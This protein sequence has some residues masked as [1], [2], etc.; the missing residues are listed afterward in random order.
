M[1]KPISCLR[2]CVIVLGV[3]G[4]LHGRLAWAQL[5]PPAGSV[6]VAASSASTPPTVTLAAALDA[7][8]GRAA[9]A[10]ESEALRRRA[11]A[12]RAVASSLWAAPPSLEFVL[13]DDRFHG[14]QGQREAEIGVTVPLW[15]PG[16]RSARG[17]TVSAAGAQAEAA[18]RVARL[19]LAGELRLAA[20]SL[21]VL[22]A[23]AAQVEAQVQTLHQLA[24][25]VER[26]VRAGDLARADALAAQAELLSARALQAEARQAARAGFGHWTLLTGLSA[27]PEL[28]AEPAALNPPMHVPLD[29]PE[30]QLARLATEHAR[31]RLDLAQQS[32]REPP[33]LLLGLRQDTAGRGQSSQGGVVV[34][35]RLPF[36]TDD[37]NLP[38]QAAAL[39]E[40]DI[41]ESTEPRL[42]DRLDSELAGARGAEQSAQA[43]Y[44]AEA[45]RARLLR[46]RA[47]LIDR[48]FRAGETA[49]PDLLRAIA[50][51]AQ[52]DSAAT[53][54]QAALG[55]AHARRQQALGLLP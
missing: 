47:T 21:V 49:L 48:S 36:G 43:Q 9:A 13:R 3:A 29:H 34:G 14:N 4:S 32:G 19:R 26:R 12:D 45:A 10:R 31:R 42:R 15:L 35:M 8:W 39:S 46:E 50:L 28:E 30:L 22:L 53:R 40:L 38:L 23:D 55:L 33:V 18:E 51:A 24:E 37:R 41:A 54:Q 44:D 1:N 52:A 5:V 20:W 11:V 27:K 6:S 2:A 7:A 25:D 17:A 16:Q